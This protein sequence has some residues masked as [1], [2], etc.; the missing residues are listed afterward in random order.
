MDAG[1]RKRDDQDAAGTP[2]RKRTR[3]SIRR[4]KDGRT[5]VVNLSS[6][7]M[8]DENLSKKRCKRKNQSA[9]VQERSKN[10]DSA[11]IFVFSSPRLSI[12]A[13]SKSP[14]VKKQRRSTFVPDKTFKFFALICKFCGQDTSDQ[15]D[16]L[17]KHCKNLKSKVKSVKGRK[18]KNAIARCHDIGAAID[19]KD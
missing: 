17:L 7:D 14:L 6:T 10:A 19:S 4:K 3:K 15:K 13:E 12:N 8:P 16:H 1:K 9:T 5:Q 11:G 18:S 2:Q